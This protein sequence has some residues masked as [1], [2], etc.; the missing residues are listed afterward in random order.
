M[1]GA[2]DSERRRFPRARIPDHTLTVLAA[3]HVRLLDINSRAVLLACPSDMPAP[4]RGDRAVLT[5]VLG[6]APFSSEVE[7]RRAEPIV[8]EGATRERRVA[9]M[10][11]GMT[12]TNRSAV[13]QFLGKATT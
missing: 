8:G 11:V 6:A 1:A 7:I 2:P 3:S 9:A 4:A 12:P 10:F 5:M 13:E